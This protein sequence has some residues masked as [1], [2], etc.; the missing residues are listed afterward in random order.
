MKIMNKT[1]CQEEF[2]NCEIVKENQRL[3][4]QNKILKEQLKGLRE[5]RDY[6]FNKYSIENEHLR[7]IINRLRMREEEWLEE[8]I[9]HE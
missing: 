4:K 3:K 6:L 7:R 8:T 1:L 9:G 5:E 2:T